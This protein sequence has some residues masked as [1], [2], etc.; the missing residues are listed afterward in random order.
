MQYIMKM[1]SNF[2]GAYPLAGKILCGFS[3][4]CFAMSAYNLFAA[5]SAAKEV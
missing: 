4:V 5:S 1:P 2:R 3:G